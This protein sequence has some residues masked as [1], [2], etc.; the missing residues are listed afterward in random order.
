MSITSYETLFL[1]QSCG[2]V[3]I[4]IFSDPILFE[5]YIAVE[6]YWLWHSGTFR[7]HG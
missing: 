5:E 3:L 6:E 1:F 4:R 7:I 2:R